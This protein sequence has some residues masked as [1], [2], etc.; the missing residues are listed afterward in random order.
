MAHSR[1]VEAIQKTKA[2][3]TRNLNANTTS[4][5]LQ[6]NDTVYLRLENRQKLDPVHSGPFKMLELSDS[7]AIIKI[8]NEITQVHKS[9]LVKL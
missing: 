2:N 7:N 4:T 9:R 8:G 6:L 5:P 3:R 1:V